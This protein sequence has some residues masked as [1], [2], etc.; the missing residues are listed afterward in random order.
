MMLLLPRM[1]VLLCP[2]PAPLVR[3][4]RV[5]QQRPVGSRVPHRQRV[6]AAGLRVAAQHSDGPLGYCTV[7]ANAAR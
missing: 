6:R 7:C 5:Q 1:Q 3:C 2:G 4:R